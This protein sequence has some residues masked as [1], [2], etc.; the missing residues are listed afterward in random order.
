MSSPTILR[1]PDWS[2]ELGVSALRQV[3]ELEDAAE[4]CR[5]PQRVSKFGHPCSKP[6][7]TG[8]AYMH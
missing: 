6:I 5:E 4:R 7:P 2:G 8:A 3:V 1:L